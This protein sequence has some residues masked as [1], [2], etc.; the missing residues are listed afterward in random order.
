LFY[1]VAM[2]GLFTVLP[3]VPATSTAALNFEPIALLLL[4]WVFLGH[5]V[6]PW[7]IAG[8]MLTVGSIVWLGASKH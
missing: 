6:S 4:A 2:V 5:A 8:A 3:R 7:Q 1:C